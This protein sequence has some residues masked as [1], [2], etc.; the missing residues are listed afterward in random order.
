MF[1]SFVECLYGKRKATHWRRA[2]GGVVVDG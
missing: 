2:G 1:F